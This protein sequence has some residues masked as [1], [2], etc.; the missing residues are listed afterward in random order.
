[1][2]RLRNALIFGVIALS[3]IAGHAQKRADSAP[4]TQRSAKRPQGFIDYALGKVNPDGKDYGAAADA[5]RQGV[6]HRSIDDLYFWS[7]LF[8]LS[9]LAG[10]S[11]G[12][13][14]QLRGSSKREVICAA[15]ITQLW[16]GRVSD[17][18]EIEQRTMQ[19]NKLVERRNAE[20]EQS[21]LTK[22]RPQDADEGSSSKIKR[23]VEKLDR[24]RASNSEPNLP[25]QQ[26]GIRQAA[27][28]PSIS[29]GL[30]S[31]PQQNMLLLEHRLETMKNTEQNLTER[32][33]QTM[34][35]LEQERQRNSSLKGA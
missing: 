9:L 2:I 11:A 4:T 25:E 28:T 15:I 29:K 24:R 21:F 10:V 14:F 30:S 3:S 5:A 22:S 7:N 19:Y 16:N 33:N 1:M 31:E 32:L 35:Q 26:S 20:V 18:I 6:V 17:A 12:F 27:P 8:S 34:F 23:K 13:Y